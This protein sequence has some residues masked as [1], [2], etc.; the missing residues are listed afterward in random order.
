MPPILKSAFRQLARA[1]GFSTVIVLTLGLGIGATTTMF[2]VINTTFLRPLP[3]PDPEQLVYID[4][5]NASGNAISTS[6]PDFIDWQARQD[7]LSALALFRIDRRTLRTERAVEQ[8]SVGFV[9][10]DFFSVLGVRVAAGRTLTPADDTPGAEPVV[11]LTHDAWQRH[12]PGESNLIGGSISL[13]GRAFS[14]AGILPPA[15]RFQR[16]MDFVVPVAPHAASLFLNQRENHNDA[17]VVGRLKAGSTIEEARAQF[18]AIGQQIEQQYPESNHGVRPMIVPL[19]EKLTGG[20]KTQLYLLLGAVGLLLL[21]TVVNVA[22][23]L[24]ARSTSRD[25]EMAVRTAL[26]A[27]G[28]QIVRQLLTESLLLAVCGGALGC[29]LSL[30]GYGFVQ[31]L[32]PWEMQAIASADGI[33]GRVFA[34]VMAVTMGAGIAFGLAPAWRLSRTRPNDALKD[35]PTLVR[36]RFGRFRLADALVIAQVGLALML[37]IG[38]GLMIR[39]LHRLTQ[40]DPGFDAAQLLTLQPAPPSMDEFGRDPLGS[41]RHYEAI[42]EHV[43]QQPGVEMA[44][45]VSALPFSADQSWLNF[46]RSD[47]PHPAGAEFP[48]ASTH[49]VTSDYFRVMGIPLR[50]GRVFTGRERSPTLAPGVELTPE[51]VS[52][53]YEGL[54]LDVVVS[55]R[56]AERFWPG[57]DPIGK[58][59]QLGFPQMQLPRAEIIGVVGNTTQLGLDQ[60]AP[61]EC[62]FSLRQFPVPY[63][64]HLVVRSHLSGTVLAPMLRNAVQVIAKDRPIL[65]LQPMTARI[66]AS[67]ERR[68]FNMTLF[69]FFAGVALL[70][71]TLGIH[72]VLAFVVSRRTRELGIRMALGAPRARVLRDV[73]GRGFGLVLVGA[74]LGLGGAWGSSRLLQSQLFGVAASD[75]WAYLGSGAVLLLAAVAACLFP[76]RR[77]TRINPVEAL[78]AE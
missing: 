12:F 46:F 25:R 63:G 31:R 38:A 35:R 73:L 6:Y 19:R 37:L 76:A 41:V 26:G 15:F 57:E 39:S 29:L 28:W 17:Y 69:T 5:V 23:M 21:V 13:G 51:V 40:I 54:V 68:R 27:S 24:L 53:A 45:F 4:E 49:V 55:Q 7:T 50:S 32:V 56:M 60:A 2:S 61:A 72:G 75:L 71:A 1:P 9:S 67:I 48:S 36:T 52:A 58:R 3:Y 34:F 78:R 8:V 44:A 62:Y 22:N 16:R 10:A 65:D 74:S 18:T 14:V 59:F 77:A 64:L 42:L 30:W 20:A 47:Q 33:D 43:L 66:G 11:W 70:L